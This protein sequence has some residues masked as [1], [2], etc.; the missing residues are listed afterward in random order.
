MSGATSDIEQAVTAFRQRRDACRRRLARFH[1]GQLAGR[2]VERYCG[3]PTNLP[4]DCSRY[5]SQVFGVRREVVRKLI[6]FENTARRCT[7]YAVDEPE[8][9]AMPIFIER[10]CG[11]RLRENDVHVA[12]VVDAECEWTL[13][14]ERRDAE[15]NN[16]AAQ[17][18]C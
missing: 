12:D 8:P 5:T 14:I 1:L 10:L 7:Q 16:R 3:E 13:R 4:P 15:H 18:Q 9:F 11:N 2:A 17:E 6:L